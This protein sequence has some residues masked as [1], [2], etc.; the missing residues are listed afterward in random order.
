MLANILP[1]ELMAINL[2]AT[3]SSCDFLIR[4]ALFSLKTCPSIV[5]Q[6]R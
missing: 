3:G 6:S 4:Y 1:E 5:G 2:A